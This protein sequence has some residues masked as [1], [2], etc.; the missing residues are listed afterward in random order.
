[1]D[2]QV[3]T[4]RC[5]VNSILTQIFPNLEEH[6]P[7]YGDYINWIIELEF[8]NLCYLICVIVLVMEETK[9]VGSINVKSGIGRMIKVKLNLMEQ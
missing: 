6:S 2:E 3:A 5:L 1:M 7:L 9:S 8:V 4:T